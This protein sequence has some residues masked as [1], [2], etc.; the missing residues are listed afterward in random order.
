M[1]KLSTAY[2]G[3]QT[4]HMKFDEIEFKEEFDGVWACASLLHVPRENID[5]IFQKIYHALKKNGIFY[6]SY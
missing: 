5:L 1:V 2:T 4:L 6:S 3:K